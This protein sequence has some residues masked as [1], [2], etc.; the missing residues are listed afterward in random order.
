[1]DKHNALQLQAPRERD[2]SR[3]IDDEAGVGTSFLALGRAL[4]SLLYAVPA[5][6]PSTLALASTVLAAAGLIACILPA[7]LA[8]RI[9]PAVAL[10]EQ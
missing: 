6:D 1:M 3:A 2:P 9:D 4:G 10:R 7:R 8:A 5:H